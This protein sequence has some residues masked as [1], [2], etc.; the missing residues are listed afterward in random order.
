MANKQELLL[1]QEK[2]YHMQFQS[3]KAIKYLLPLKQLLWLE[4][5]HPI[6]LPK[7]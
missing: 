1:T 3:L 7:F 5:Q 2:D 6:G 4:D